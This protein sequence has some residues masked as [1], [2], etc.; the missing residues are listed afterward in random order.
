MKI[1]QNTESLTESLTF[2]N[3]TWNQAWLNKDVATVSRMM[4]D[5]Y[6]YVAPNGEVCDRREVLRII[7]SET[8]QLVSGERT[9]V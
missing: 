8:Y 7:E 1:T 2:F 5:D 3:R 6:V 4:A 9:E